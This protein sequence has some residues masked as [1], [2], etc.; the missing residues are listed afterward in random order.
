VVAAGN[1]GCLTQIA[2]H[3]PEARFIHTVELADWLTGG[4]VPDALAG[5]VDDG[6]VE[7]VA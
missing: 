2:A 5:V 4:P 6:L 3:M 7:E 1:L